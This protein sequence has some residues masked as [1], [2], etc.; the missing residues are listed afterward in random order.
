AR[1]AG[2][3]AWRRVTRAALAHPAS[4]NL[5]L[6]R[7]P[8]SLLGGCTLVLAFEGRPEVVEAE[9][10]VALDLL[11]ASARD[12][13]PEPALAWFRRRYAISYRQSPTFAAGGFNDTMEVAATWDR[14]MD[15]YAAVRRAIG[16]KVLV[17]AHFSHAY[18]EGC[19]IYFTFAG[20]APSDAEALETYDEV[21]S[22]G[23]AAV[24]EAGGVISH[25][26]GVGMSKLAAME[27]EYGGA[28]EI[29]RA[30]KRALDPSGMLNPGKLFD[31]REHPVA[32]QAPSTTTTSTVGALHA[33]LERAVPGGV[34]AEGD[35]PMF[36]VTPGDAYE[37]AACLRIACERRV[38]VVARSETAQARLPEGQVA[39][40]LS[41][42]RMQAVRRICE[43]SLTVH[44]EAGIRVRALE[45]RLAEH[46]LSLG[47]PLLPDAAP[48]LGGL[49][50]GR[51]WG[52]G[53]AALGSFE[54]ACVGLEA[55][56]PRGEAIRIKPSPR[57][58]AGPDMMQAL[59]GAEG[60]FGV[61]TGAILRVYRAPRARR[62]VG[63][64][65]GDARG[66]VACLAGMLADSF[67]PAAARV[68]RPG[69]AWGTTS[70]DGE[71]AL[72]LAFEGEARLV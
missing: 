61:I 39:V 69:P 71:A 30:M 64:W 8:D 55:V 3:A 45:E 72:V 53:S 27:G 7:L 43:E 15:V 51:G 48:K 35:P 41:L 70:G 42:E 33:C 5:A 36:V 10:R 50:G 6:D 9:E 24:I 40:V 67:R 29:A 68:V 2:R 60:A 13:G 58:A 16:R 57:R 18:H 66:A 54:E 37:L 4:L 31:P 44:A 21:W 38:P 56:L 23:L 19:S 11:S 25:H 52:E 62:I 32:G 17:M 1:A 12:A 46:A 63:A 22:A 26:H 47:Y 59:V 65:F 28:L 20:S 14:L 34:A 49:L